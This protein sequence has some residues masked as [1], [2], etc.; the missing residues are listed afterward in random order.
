M[1]KIPEDSAITNSENASSRIDRVLRRFDRGHADKCVQRESPP[2]RLMVDFV[3]WKRPVA[4]P[5]STP[6]ITFEP[7]RTSIS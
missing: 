7:D 6:V 4:K 3:S 1:E 2:R 5:L